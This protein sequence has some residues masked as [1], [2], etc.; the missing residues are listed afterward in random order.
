LPVGILE[1]LDIPTQ[2]QCYAG[3]KADESPR[4][5]ICDSTWIEVEEVLDRWYQGDRDP[6]WPIADYFKVKGDDGHEYVLKHD[7]D[8]NEW[9]V[10]NR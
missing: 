4:R 1:G 10:A 3:Y 7:R 8:H 5:F 6:E 9:F 2:V